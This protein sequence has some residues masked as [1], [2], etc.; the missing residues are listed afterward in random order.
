MPEYLFVKYPLPR[1]VLVDGVDQ[2][3]VNELLELE[4]GQHSASLVGPV[5]FSPDQY[6]VWLANTDPL[7]PVMVSFTPK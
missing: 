7:D 1:R 2:G 5:D 3:P 6:I 4:A